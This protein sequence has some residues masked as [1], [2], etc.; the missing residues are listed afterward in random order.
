MV[1][2]LGGVPSFPASTL[3]SWWLY[4]AWLLQN[5]LLVH[6]FYERLEGFLRPCFFICLA[7]FL[8]CHQYL[9]L[10]LG[11]SS[12]QK[13]LL[14]PY[15]SHAILWTLCTVQTLAP[16]SLLE[17]NNYLGFSP[18]FNH[19][20][21][22]CFSGISNP[23]KFVRHL[24]L[25]PRCRENLCLKIFYSAQIK[26]FNYAIFT[27]LKRVHPQE[28]ESLWIFSISYTNKNLFLK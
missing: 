9:S 25:F 24:F 12:K 2:C 14:E 16:L 11:I 7:D 22:Y 28:F 26:M 13:R 23:Q 20:S 27:V 1:S 4:V 21:T 6:F 19:G 3:I 17:K 8:S 18:Q 5:K 15:T 10:M